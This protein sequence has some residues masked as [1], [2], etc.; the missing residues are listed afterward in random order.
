MRL[1]VLSGRGVGAWELNL[2]DKERL[3]ELAKEI[4]L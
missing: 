1:D 4:L 3:R 2:R